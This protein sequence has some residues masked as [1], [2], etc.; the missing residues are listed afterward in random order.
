LHGKR[1]GCV[2]A[3]PRSGTWNVMADLCDQI[4]LPPSHGMVYDVALRK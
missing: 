4:T 2:A 3:L 1:Y